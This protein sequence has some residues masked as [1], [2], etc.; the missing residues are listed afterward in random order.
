[1]SN[2]PPYRP[3]SSYYFFYFA[4]LGAFVPY[5]SVYLEQLDYSASEIGELMAI[6]ML[7]KLV[8]PIIWGWIVDYNGQ[9]LA[10]IQRASWLSILSILPILWF[11]AA[12]YWIMFLSLGLLGFFWN[13]SLPQYEALTLNHLG[14]QKARY[15]H[16]RLWGSLGFIIA[17]AGVSLII[18]YD[19]ITTLPVIVLGLLFLTWVMTGLVKDKEHELC[20]S[21]EQGLLKLLATPRI[22][23]LLIA[24]ALHT[25]AHGAYYTFY[26]IYLADIGYTPIAIGALWSLGVFAE[27]ILFLVLHKIIKHF[28][29]TMLFIISLVLAL[30][31]WLALAVITNSTT[32]LI[33]VQLLHAA[34]YGLFHATAIQQ[35]HQWFPK[36]LQGMGQALYAGLSFGLGGALGSLLSGYL[37][38]STSPMLTFSVMAGCS[39]LAIIF[40]IVF[41]R[42][43]QKNAIQ[44]TI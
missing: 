38:H 12:S 16:I 27:I 11:S 18:K 21:D 33:L 34:S 26:S 25:M 9:R 41:M 37:W 30:I 3:L 35:I 19:S 8:A 36:R 44:P 13:A 39:V 32:T 28:D 42:K 14:E 4:A 5:W 20:T 6:F 1:M 2:T 17:I 31:R 29:I 10:W 7:G 24:S 40:A 43:P 23:G 15:P 22:A